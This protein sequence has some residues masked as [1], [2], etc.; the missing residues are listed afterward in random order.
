[1]VY[2]SLKVKNEE[3]KKKNEETATDT[4]TLTDTT[5]SQGETPGTPEH[6]KQETGSRKNRNHKVTQSH[7]KGRARCENPHGFSRFPLCDFFDFVVP[8]SSCFDVQPR[9]TAPDT[10]G[11][12]AVTDTT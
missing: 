5:G 11:S 9:K 4:Q 1:M 2:I 3:R 6:M 7:T 10:K 12:Q 8:L